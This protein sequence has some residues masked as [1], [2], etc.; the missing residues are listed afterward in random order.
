MHI[1]D[2]HEF[3]EMYRGDKDLRLGIELCKN[4]DDKYTM[5]V[6]NIASPADSKFFDTKEFP[7]DRLPELP[8]G[9]RIEYIKSKLIY[10]SKQN[11][12]LGGFFQFSSDYL[13]VYKKLKPDLIFENPYTTLTP[14]SYMSFF[15][16]KGQGIPIVYIDPGDIPPK[17]RVKNIINKIEKNIISY[18]HD[19]ITY[20]KMGK[21]RFIDE[22]NYPEEKL[23]VIPKPIDIERFTPGKGRK[24]IRHKLEIDDRF[25]VSYIGRLS[26][27]KGCH[28]LMGVAKQIKD[29][30][31]D[32]EFYFLFVG[33][34]IIEKDAVTIRDLQKKYDLK[35]VH[36]TGQVPYDEIVKYQAASDIVVFPDSTNLPGFSTVLAESMAMGKVIIKG[37]KGFEDAMPLKHL[38]TGIIIEPRNENEIRKWIV[39]LKD[40]ESLC[41]NIET[42]VRRFAE[43]HMDWKKQVNVYRE[44]FERAI[45]E[46]KD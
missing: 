19:I 16:A 40:D 44:I 45:N 6:P 9:M 25:V 5:L 30:G 35:N 38:E 46:N 4:Y 21:N 43:E 31:R 28:H 11:L 32:N 13:S 10:F 27:N 2:S 7:S 1:V 3:V 36:F 22:Y 8:D 24:E 23:H 18:A 37:I 29:L 34:N 26:N 42:N 33:G 41:N 14:R 39:K 20:S 12:S 15:A 17:G